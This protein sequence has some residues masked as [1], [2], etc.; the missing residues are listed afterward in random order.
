[1]KIIENLTTESILNKQ[2]PINELLENT[3]YYPSS[4]FDYGIIKYYGKKIQ[5][6]IYCDYA[7]GEEA[8]LSQLDCFR[9]YKILGHRPVRQEELVPNGWKMQP[10]PNFNFKQY[11]I[12]KDAFKKPFAHWVVY[13]KMANFS[14][15]D[16]PNRFS[17][18]YIGGEGVATYQALYWSN[19]KTAKA[20][21][22]IQPGTSF[23]LNWTNFNDKNGALAWVVMNNKFGIPD[24]IF[25]GG[26][27]NGYN[28]FNWDNYV[29][30]RTIRP[31]YSEQPFGEVTIWTRK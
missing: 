14:E 20:L 16:G 21:A 13:E 29:L 3:F 24:T 18:I 7:T 2:L 28:D 30:S 23:G 17:L 11:Y 15:S 9:G 5:S 6:Y 25:Y 1:M 31:Y 4:G 10:P 27:G 26:Y 22:I 12:H 19:K 8:F